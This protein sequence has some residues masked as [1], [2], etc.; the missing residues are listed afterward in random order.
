M[1]RDL[2][3][4]VKNPSLSLWQSVVTE[5]V[6]HQ[7]GF[8]AA[9]HLSLTQAV[10]AHPMVAATNEVAVRLDAGGKEAVDSPAALITEEQ[11]FTYLSELGYRLGQAYS[12]ENT[13]LVAELEA[14]FRKYSDKDPGFLTC[15]TT[16]YEYR[17]KYNGVLKYNDWERQG[18]GNRDYGVIQYRLPNNAKVAILGDWG[19]G[20]D[21]AR[22]LLKQL[23]VQHHPDAII[24]LGDIYY[25]GTPEECYLN[26]AQ[27]FDDVFREVLGA[28]QR[29]PVFSIPG[30]H[31]Y[32]AFGYGYYDMVTALNNFKREAVQPASYFSL[33]TAD[34]RWQLLGMD[35]GYD[36]A[37]PLDQ[38][39]PYYAGPQLHA[40]EV[41][42]LHD[43]LDR[44]KGS[45]ILLSHHQLFT[46][47][48]KINGR[49]SRFS[50]FPF[51]NNYLYGYFAP[52]FN[53]KVAGW[54]WGHEHNFVA[55]RNGLG[56]LQK[57]RLVG[58]SAYEE[59]TSADPYQVNNLQ[60]PYLDPLR[61]RLDA[62][63]GY[64]NHGYAIIDFGT[65][66]QPE[67]AVQ[68]S[69]YQYPSWGDQ[70]PHLPIQAQL[71][72]EENW[73]QPSGEKGKVVQYGAPLRISLMNL[74]YYFSKAY[75]GKFNY[76]YGTTGAQAVTLRLQGSSGTLMEGD[77]VSIE[78]LDS[79]VG[80]YNRLKASTNHWLYYDKPSSSS[81]EQW[82]VQKMHTNGDR[83][84]HEGEPVY[85]L[86]KA[87][88]GQY[89]TLS[90]DNYLTTKA[91]VPTP[92]TF[93]LN[94]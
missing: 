3:S 59:L 24:H 68:V 19:T 4:R 6:R 66:L 23:M 16:Y 67:D 43:K 11:L 91:D 21:D 27:V 71:M 1:H 48:G 17:K 46:T 53:N 77:L 37:S 73:Q 92:W 65:R 22:H 5:Y 52:Y 35:T 7:P 78:T 74:D 93:R 90:S 8:T 64:Y 61:Y 58:C 79:S 89:L 9:Q 51:I 94:G 14:S 76:F 2:L 87:Y 57:G 44:F 18:G 84:V 36:D 41:K 13:Q 80:S 83:F 12:Q 45:T 25:S 85:L 30:N 55:Y 34:E 10:L 56:G 75:A 20:M 28:G 49:L 50:H 33:Q 63:N 40:S 29:I 72:L 42:W 62:A 69:Y 88:P 81:G 86:S 60:I 26:F 82:L 47:N 31:D 54:L 32:Y 70:Q 38:L 39:D 15:A